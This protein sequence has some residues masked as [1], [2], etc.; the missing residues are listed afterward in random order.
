[1]FPCARH[2]KKGTWWWWE[3]CPVSGHLPGFS[4]FGAT[5]TF[6]KP[7]PKT[8]LFKGI[9]DVMSA[10]GQNSQRIDRRS[11]TC[12]AKGFLKHKKPAIRQRT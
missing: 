11:L 6:P 9:G 5:I 10:C 7:I 1:M 4:P 3:I 8:L 12:P 2:A